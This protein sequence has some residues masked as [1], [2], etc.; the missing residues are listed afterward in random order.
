MPNFASALKEEIVR[1]ARKEIR[2]ETEGFN[3]AKAQFRSETT[4]LKHRVA[5]LEKQVARL[6]RKE[7]KAQ[8]ANPNNGKE[9]KVRFRAKGLVTL[10]RRLGLS[11]AEFGLLAGVSAQTIYNWEAE[12]S[13]PRQ[14]QIVALASLR[15]MGK[16]QA[17]AKLGELQGK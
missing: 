6:S 12:K 17:T 9:A 4:A 16:K 13:R 2:I 3:K 10:R 15:A 1:L 5:V 7:S 8:D 11:A 14:Q